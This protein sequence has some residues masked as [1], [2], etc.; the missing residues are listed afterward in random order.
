MQRS[1]GRRWGEHW[2]LESL[3]GTGSGLWPAPYG[4][5]LN[6]WIYSIVWRLP[7]VYMKGCAL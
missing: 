7:S 4:G 3:S 6:A 1:S 5:Q 2:V